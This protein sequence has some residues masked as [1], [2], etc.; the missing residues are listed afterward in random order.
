MKRATR[1]AVLCLVLLVAHSGLAEVRTW[2]GNNGVSLDAEFVRLQGDGVSLVLR[3]RDG[4]LMQTKT[5]NLSSDDQVYVNAL[6]TAIRAAQS[7]RAAEQ[8]RVQP[9]TQVQGE[10]PALKQT[11]PPQSNRKPLPQPL[12]NAM[13]EADDDKL[14]LKDG[15][16]P[17]R[18]RLMEVDDDDAMLFDQPGQWQRQ[19][20]PAVNRRRQP[21][22]NPVAVPLGRNGRNRAWDEA[23]D[24]TARWKKQQ[25]EQDQWRKRQEEQRV[26]AEKDM[27]RSRAFQ[28]EGRV[29]DSRY[30]SRADYSGMS[31]E[32]SFLSQDASR[33][34]ESGAAWQFGNAASKLREMERDQ[35]SLWNRQNDSL[36]SRFDSNR[37]EAER[38]VW[39]GRSSVDPFGSR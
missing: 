16:D 6:V 13:N 21:L 1:Y 33:L 25:D 36:G 27:I 28:L 2:T 39:G 9:Q 19:N 5:Y 29:R 8:P 22:P 37:R 14:Q 10:P 17:A 26:Q 15:R 18:R 23:E 30:N 11:P 3:K 24:T 34:G 20:M 4:S 32:A 35:N 31:R 7:A 38:D 12:S